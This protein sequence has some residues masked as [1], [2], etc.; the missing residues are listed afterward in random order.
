VIEVASRETGRPR[1][2]RS[3]TRAIAEAIALVRLHAPLGEADTVRTI[4]QHRFAA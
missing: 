1:G 3:D 2:D 4:T